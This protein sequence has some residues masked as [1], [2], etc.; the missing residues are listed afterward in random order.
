MDWPLR[1]LHEEVKP[2]A[3]TR[4]AP[5]PP[6]AW[7]GQQHHAQRVSAGDGEAEQQSSEVRDAEGPALPWE[8]PF[9]LRNA[10]R[11]PVANSRICPGTL[12]GEKSGPSC[13]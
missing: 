3:G 7:E 9:L 1:A 6:R 13:S 5:G 2:G 11:W 4:H 8:S 12:S 10:E